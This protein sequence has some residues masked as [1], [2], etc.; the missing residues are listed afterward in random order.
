MKFSI[1]YQLV[2]Q[3][4]GPEAAQGLFMQFS[5][6]DPIEVMKSEDVEID[7]KFANQVLALMKG[8][9][10]RHVLVKTKIAPY[11]GKELINYIQWN[12]PGKGKMEVR[13]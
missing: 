11:T 7:Y 1:F 10:A 3:Q 5:L 4:S 2:K 6:N 13:C 8:T 12:A 9:G